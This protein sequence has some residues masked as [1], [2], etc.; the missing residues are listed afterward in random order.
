MELYGNLVIGGGGINLYDP[1]TVAPGQTVYTSAGSYSWVAPANVTSVSVVCVGAGGGAGM[2]NGGGGGGG[3]LFYRNNI[4]VTPGNTYT[5]VVGARGQ[6]NR[7]SGGGYQ[8]I[9]ATKGGDTSAFG[10]IAGGGNAGNS[11]ASSTP[12]NVGGIPSAGGLPSGIYDV[13]W[14]GG[15]GGGTRNWGGAGG[16]AGGYA[17]RGGNANVYVHPYNAQVNVQEQPGTAGTAGEGGG[18][19]AGFATFGAGVQKNNI[20]T[21]LPSGHGGGTGLYGIGANGAA[22]TG[23]LADKHGK[24]GSGGGNGSDDPYEY[25]LY[26]GEGGSPGGGGGGNMGDG[27]N[28]ATGTNGLN[29]RGAPGGVR[30]I[31]PGVIRKFPDIRTANE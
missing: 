22:G 27:I 11:G 1:Y 6:A 15:Q 29:G 14:P 28:V 26:R 18:G 23:T 2:Y 30:I 12:T 3:A 24:G 9:T 10:A 20:S 19:G 4:S 8:L 7:G 31:W 5:I 16:G 25:E 13:G 21:D 17:G